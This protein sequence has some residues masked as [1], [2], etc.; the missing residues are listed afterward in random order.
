MPDALPALER[1]ELFAQLAAGH[2]AGV[3][4]VTPNRRLALALAGEFDRRQLAAGRTAWE[5]ASTWSR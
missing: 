5:T 3:T 4:V 1:E 2:A